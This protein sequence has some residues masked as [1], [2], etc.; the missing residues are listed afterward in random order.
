MGVIIWMEPMRSPERVE[1]GL[2]TVRVLGEE[3][4]VVSGE[5]TAPFWV[6]Q[7]VAAAVETAVLG[8]RVAVGLLVS[9]ARDAQWCVGQSHRRYVFGAIHRAQA[10]P[11]AKFETAVIASGHE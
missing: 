4:P 1:T 7:I 10:K 11:A 8:V 6:L 2:L 3:D 5:G 9:Q